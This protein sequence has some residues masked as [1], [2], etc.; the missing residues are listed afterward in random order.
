MTEKRARKEQRRRR[1]K[2][3]ARTLP[4]SNGR[5]TGAFIGPIAVEMTAWDAERWNASPDREAFEGEPMCP[6][7]HY[8]LVADSTP[9][10]GPWRGS[11]SVFHVPL[12]SRP[13]EA[14]FDVVAQVA[15]LV[16]V[17]LTD[18]EPVLYNNVP[19][20]QVGPAE[21]PISRQEGLRRLEA[22]SE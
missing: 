9:A 19:E 5:A 13:S 2:T 20:W 16:G 8:T 12:D 21:P 1:R 18:L 3:S 7:E 11:V 17:R 15:E 14:A 6:P 4:R 22:A 10:T